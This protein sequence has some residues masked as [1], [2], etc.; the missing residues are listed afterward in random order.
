MPTRMTEPF[1]LRFPDQTKRSTCNKDLSTFVRYKLKI[2]N[3]T[4]RFGSI[5]N[6]GIIEHWFL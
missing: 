5:K 3:M 2:E 1:Q 4:Q 6:L